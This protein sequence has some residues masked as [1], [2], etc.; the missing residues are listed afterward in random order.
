MNEKRLAVV[1][2]AWQALDDAGAG[3]VSAEDLKI[4][5]YPAVRTLLNYRLIPE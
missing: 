3:R 1:K 4:K 5:Y 2:H